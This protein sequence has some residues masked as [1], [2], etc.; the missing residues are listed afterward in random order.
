[1]NHTQKI[2]TQWWCQ[3]TKQHAAELQA[4]GVSLV[5]W[6]EIIIIKYS[7]AEHGGVNAVTQVKDGDETR[8]LYVDVVVFPL[9]DLDEDGEH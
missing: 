2:Q 6:C 3:A 4:V 7:D 8:H 9:S 1:M 5:M